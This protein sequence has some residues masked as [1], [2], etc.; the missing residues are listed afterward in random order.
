M[1]GD[2][3][4][5]AWPSDGF[6][7]IG[8]ERHLEA[9]LVDAEAAFAAAEIAERLGDIVEVEREPARGERGACA[10]PIAGQHIAR[11]KIRGGFRLSGTRGVLGVPGYERAG[12]ADR[13]KEQA[14]ANLAGSRVHGTTHPHYNETVSSDPPAR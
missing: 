4:H 3:K 13:R 10:V 12:E 6:L 7:E 9:A 14:R 8:F 11:P 1:A 5:A 2:A